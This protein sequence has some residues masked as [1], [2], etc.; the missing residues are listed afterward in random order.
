MK[1]EGCLR[2]SRKMAIKLKDVLFM[3]DMRDIIRGITRGI[4]RS[5]S[6]RNVRRQIQ[7]YI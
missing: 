2:L 5:V 6:G 4:M 7:E 1:I 3:R